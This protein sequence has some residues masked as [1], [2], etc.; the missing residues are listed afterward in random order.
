MEQAERVEV[1]DQMPTDPIL[2]DEV[3]DAVLDPRQ[4]ESLMGLFVA[5]I[6]ILAG[7]L[8]GGRF[9]DDEL[10]EILSPGI[11]NTRRVA[12]ELDVQVVDVVQR[13]A[14]HGGSE[15]Q[16]ESEGGGGSAWKQA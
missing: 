5:A 9:A 2:A 11:G 7:R 15:S 6:A 3:V 8:L 10:F 16:S 13:I 14:I 4:P 1:G 12:N